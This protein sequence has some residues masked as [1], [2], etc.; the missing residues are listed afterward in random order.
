MNWPDP[1][2]VYILC[3]SVP[4]IRGEYVAGNG[5]N[6]RIR[7]D[8]EGQREKAKM[9]IE[10]HRRI[11][12]ARRSEYKS[13]DWNILLFVKPANISDTWL[14]LNLKIYEASAV[15]PL[16][17]PFPNVREFKIFRFRVNSRGN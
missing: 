17:F 2:H 9:K 12:H 15:S 16:L 6:G 11:E 3:K 8:E 13:R 7:S 4:S 1:F 10:S 5:E 14:A